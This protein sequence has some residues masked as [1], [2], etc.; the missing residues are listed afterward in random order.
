MSERFRAALKDLSISQLRKLERL[1]V[2]LQSPDVTVDDLLA[3]VG[4]PASVLGEE[5]ADL[6][7]ARAYELSLTDMIADS[8]ALEAQAIE[9]HRAGR[10]DK[11]KPPRPRNRKPKA[12]PR[13]EVLPAAAA[14][15]QAIPT[16]AQAISTPPVSEA[17]SSNVIPLRK[18][19][20]S[21]EDS[22]F[23]PKAFGIGR[24]RYW[25]GGEV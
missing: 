23:G 4:R 9:D 21:Q 3:Q 7:A 5:A 18:R 10:L 13:S 6:I 16:A 8:A 2:Q 17:P 15:T 24:E 14:S 19:E 25:I 22:Y 12:K 11:P 20:A 1:L